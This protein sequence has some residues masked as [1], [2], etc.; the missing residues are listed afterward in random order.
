MVKVWFCI[1]CIVLKRQ[2][3]E[4]ETVGVAEQADAEQADAAHDKA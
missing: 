2:W 3:F 1:G 4:L